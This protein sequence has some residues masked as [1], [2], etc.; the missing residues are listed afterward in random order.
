[1][2]R[3][4]GKIPTRP[5]NARLSAQTRKYLEKL[6]KTGVH[7]YT[8]TEVA[9]VLIWDQIKALISQGVLKWEGDPETAPDDAT[10]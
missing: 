10:K 5:I 8:P 1:M 9:K 6:T 3:V 7:G 2:P 4:S